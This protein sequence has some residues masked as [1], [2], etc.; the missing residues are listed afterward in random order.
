MYWAPKNVGDESAWQQI[1]CLIAIDELE[2]LHNKNSL[3]IKVYVNDMEE[4]WIAADSI[5]RIEELPKGASQW[6]N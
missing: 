2:R 6:K 1:K 4:K 3:F 5:N